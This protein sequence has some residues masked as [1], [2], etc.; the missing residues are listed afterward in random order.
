MPNNYVP[1]RMLID[2]WA[3]Q[4]GELPQVILTN[5]CEHEARSRFP[6][7]TFRL[8][9]TGGWGDPGSLSELTNR[10]RWSRY[11]FIR[12][13]AARTLGTLVASKAGVLSFCKLTGTRPPRCVAGFWRWLFWPKARHA[14]PPPYPSTPEEIRAERAK[15]EREGTAARARHEVELESHAEERLSHVEM[16]LR[17]FEE[18]IRK[19]EEIDWDY[20]LDD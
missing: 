3:R 12:E 11:D 9:G 7:A 8:T 16:I 15:A 4:S 1:L 14:A 20:W 10:V 6:P 13:D 2:E 18:L 19:G 17:R 5:L